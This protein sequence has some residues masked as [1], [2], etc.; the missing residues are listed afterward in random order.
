MINIYVMN[1]SPFE[2]SFLFSKGLSLIEKERQ[3]KVKH[4]KREDVKRLSLGAGLV[5]LYGLNHFLGQKDGNVKAVEDRKLP[6][7]ESETVPAQSFE[8]GACEVVDSWDLS[9]M[10]NVFHYSYGPHGKPYVE[11]TNPIFFSLSHSGDY[12]LLAVSDKEIGA[13]IQLRKDGELQR[14]AKHFMTQEE[15][16]LWSEQP[17]AQQKE[18]F[19]Q[20]W[21]GKEAYLKLTGEGMTAGFQTV[22]LDAQRATMVDTRMPDK[23]VTTLWYEHEDYQ[24]AIC[25]FT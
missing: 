6:Q 9:V 4:L 3:D 12:V 19:Y 15:F 23:E 10:T 1:V 13:D 20:I 18:L 5:L 25:Q 2:D 11:G 22:R 21:A 8:I 17:P 24:I 14:I 16:Q 7:K